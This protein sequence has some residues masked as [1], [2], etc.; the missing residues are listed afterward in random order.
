[1]PPKHDPDANSAQKALALFNL[2]LFNGRSFSLTELAEELYCSKQTVLRLADLMERCPDISLE[3]ETIDRRLHLRLTP[4]ARTPRVCL[5]AQEIQQL[6]LCRDFVLHLLPEAMRQ[7]VDRAIARSA[8]LLA[9]PA[10]RPAALA[11]VAQASVKGHID[12]TAQGGLLQTLCA[13]IQDRQVCE[14]RYQA[15]SKPTPSVHHIAP[16]RLVAYR[17]ALYLHAYKVTERAVPEIVVA[18]LLAVHRLKE[19][20]PLRRHFDLP[21][22]DQET[23][24]LFGLMAFQPF[25]VAARFSA[26]AAPYVRERRWSTDQ[27]LTDEPDGGVTLRFLA[28]SEAE[29]LSWILGF[30]PEAELL[31][32]SAL[33]RALAEQAATLAAR[34]ASEPDRSP[35]V[36]KQQ[37]HAAPI[38]A[39]NGS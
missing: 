23:D 13:A 28:R 37:P 29:V 17:A 36:K 22:P 18:M 11:S 6:V 31:E 4:P 16:L 39:P 34:Y 27:T 33:R 8:T 35:D 21:E 3:R 20:T 12:Y 5:S 26:G 19:L 25:A 1:M 7:N 24:G 32:P 15:A 38:D 14:V 2:L 30:G 10:V 9:D